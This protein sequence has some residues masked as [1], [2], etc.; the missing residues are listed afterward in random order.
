M[1]ESD[2]YRDIKIPKTLTDTISTGVKQDALFPT[3]LDAVA[4]S[5]ALTL[6]GNMFCIM[7]DYY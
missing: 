1:I 2:R 7:I 5:N 3:I 6:F 4:K